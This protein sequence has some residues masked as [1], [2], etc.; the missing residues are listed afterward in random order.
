MAVGLPA[1]D[2][3]P[4]EEKARMAERN[5]QLRMLIGAL[6]EL[7]QGSTQAAVTLL[8]ATAKE[9]KETHS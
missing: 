3:V 1:R 7:P 8:E 6:K 2:H 9:E 4:P 5:R